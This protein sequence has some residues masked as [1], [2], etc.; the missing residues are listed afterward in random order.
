[1]AGMHFLPEHSRIIVLLLEAAKAEPPTVIVKAVPPSQYP[2]P[3]M[4]L[5]H[6]TALAAVVGGLF[7]VFKYLHEIKKARDDQEESRKQAALTAAVEAR[8]P[9][10]ARQQEVYFDLVNTTSILGNNYASTQK[11]QK[12]FKRF[13]ELYWGEIPVVADAVTGAGDLSFASATRLSWLRW[14]MTELEKR[15]MWSGVMMPPDLRCFIARCNMPCRTMSASC[16]VNQRAHCRWLGG[17]VLN[18]LRHRFC[19]SV[20]VMLPPLLA[21]A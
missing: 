6:L 4:I 17:S 5:S 15:I 7:A 8:K 3:E 12:A 11:W 2:I 14:F 9:F 10:L 13:W 19:S 20:I 1:M 16:R 18:M 21:L